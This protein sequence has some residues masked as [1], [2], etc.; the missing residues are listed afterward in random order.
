[1]PAH[2]LSDRTRRRTAE[3]MGERQRLPVQTKR[4]FTAAEAIAPAFSS[5]DGLPAG[6]RYDKSERHG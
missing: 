4:T 3:A 6:S 2:P 1:M 5:P